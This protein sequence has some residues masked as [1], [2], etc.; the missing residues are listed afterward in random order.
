MKVKVKVKSNPTQTILRTRR[1][2]QRSCI[3]CRETKSKRELIRL[4]RTPHAVEVDTNGK[5]AG[6]G[7]YLCPVRECWDTGLKG[8]RLEYTLRIKLAPEN[9]KML[10]EY[11]NSLP[12][13]REP[14]DE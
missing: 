4:V 7:A 1:I 6:R 9:R 11:G 3:A 13:K 8:N 14:K 5:K 2:P 10:V 12:E